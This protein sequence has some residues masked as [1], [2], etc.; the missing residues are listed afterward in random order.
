MSKE[1]LENMDSEELDELVHDMKAQ[2]A[3][4]INNRGKEAQVD[5]LLDECGV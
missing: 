5:Y 4:M 3:A 2:E 1:E